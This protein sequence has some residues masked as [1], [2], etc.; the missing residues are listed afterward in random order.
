M[1]GGGR[2]VVMGE[3][4]FAAAHIVPRPART[5]PR[6]ASALNGIPFLKILLNHNAQLTIIH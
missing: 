6:N 4:F 2:G 1:D 3:F 5:I